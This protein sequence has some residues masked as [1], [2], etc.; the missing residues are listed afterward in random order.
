MRFLVF[1][2][3]LLTAGSV[4]PQ[5]I[6]YDFDYSKPLNQS[7]ATE[8]T[9]VGNSVSAML[10]VGDTLWIGTSR[11]LSRSTDNGVSWVNYYD[12]QGFGKHSISAIAHDPV[13]STMWVALAK[14]VETLGQQL[15]AGAGLLYSKNGGNTWTYLAQPLDAQTDSVVVYGINRIK[16]VPVTVD[17]QNITYDIA[18]Y[19]NVVYTA[20]FAGGLRR[21]KDY[22]VTWER[23]VLPPDYS[24]S[25]KP[26]DTLSFCLSPVGGKI[27][28][29]GNLNHRLF[30]VIA[31]NDSLVFCG[32]ANGINKSTDGGVSWIK[33]NHQNS[34]SPITGNFVVGMN[35]N[36]FN[37]TLWAATWKAEDQNEEYGLSYSTDGGKSWGNALQG[38]KVNNIAAYKNFVIASTNTGAYQKSSSNQVWYAAQ[39][40]IDE[41]SGL[42]L[43]TNSFYSSAFTQDGLYS[44]LGSD[45]G[46]VRNER[47]VGDSW[48]PKWRLTIASRPISGD[49]EHY[50]FPN[51]F[52]PRLGSTA[53]KYSVGSASK[54]VTIRIFD[55]GMNYVKTIIQNEARGAGV[56]T[57]GTDG[58]V[59]DY[60]DGTDDNSHYV[61]NGVY[62]YRIELDDSE[63]FYGKIL[64]VQ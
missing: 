8:G 33:Y 48:S 45:N 49:V 12:T 20:S 62:F 37:N 61:P 64:V 11:G 25:I 46:L 31:V 19:N 16:A 53:I 55:F 27:C 15:P 9:P 40:I 1:S 5:S 2:I 39:Q 52:S 38:E 21:T 63:V 58:S 30:S 23:V 41:V 13:T 26:T 59:I 51:P 18:V 4:F 24:N 3:L 36:S 60:W 10:A 17:I 44:W 34:E 47:S 42:E 32:S 35:Y 54:K 6:P 56:H 22:G 43:Q 14:T 57:T 7:A 29:E 28:A 50:A